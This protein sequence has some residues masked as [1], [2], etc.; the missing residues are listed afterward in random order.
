M[1]KVIT[2]ITTA[3]TALSALSAIP[4]S[5]EVYGDFEF[6]V[7]LT[8]EYTGI[9]ITA[10]NGEASNVVIPETIVGMPVISIGEEVFRDNF[11]LTDV[12]LPET[13]KEIKYS[14]FGNCRCLKNI[15]MPADLERV[16]EYAFT[17][18][19][20]LSSLEF[21]DKLTYVGANGFQ[22]CTSLDKL[23]IPSSLQT[24]TYHSF[25]GLQGLEVLRFEEG[26]K[27]IEEDAFLN[28]FDLQK[29]YLPR[30]IESIPDYTLGCLYWGGYIVNDDVVFY[31]YSGTA[32]DYAE[33]FNF[34]FVNMCL[35][36]VNG[37]GAVNA[38]DASMILTE[39]AAAATD[40]ESVLTED[41]N[42]LADT[43]LDGAINALDAS[44]VLSY[45][46][47]TATGGSGDFIEYLGL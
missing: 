15:N 31:G 32:E 45:Y 1:K 11:V 9:E 40:S 3:A 20:A 26:V 39:Y 28:E 8:E 29:I 14:A 46:A 13:V 23:T 34:T 27:V 38:L 43:D 24:V 2:A 33:K 21:G 10:Y 37:D 4:A 19:H 6:E 41:Q 5:A 12:K 42:S 30:S 36:D 7:L 17:T 16:E 25:H 44:S 47:H 35:G 18:C 22:L